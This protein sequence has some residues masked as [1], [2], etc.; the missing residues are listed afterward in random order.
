MTR[1][2]LPPPPDICIT[3]EDVH[4][5]PLLH[6]RERPE[7]PAAGKAWY[8]VRFGPEDVGTETWLTGRL[9]WVEM[10]AGLALESRTVD[11][12]QRVGGAAVTREEAAIA[13]RAFLWRSALASDAALADM[14]T[15]AE[16]D[17]LR[18]SGDLP[19]PVADSIRV[20]ELRGELARLEG[21]AAQ[22]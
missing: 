4:A 16:L 10:P 17:Q 5:L 1:T 12:A 6:Q 9:V 2:P 18:A 20:A 11:T 21:R 13:E 22:A 14:V 8:L 15:D 3:R 7:Q 19:G